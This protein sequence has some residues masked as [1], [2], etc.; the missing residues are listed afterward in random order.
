MVNKGSQR[1]QK[2]PPLRSGFSAP[3]G[4]VIPYGEVNY[5]AKNDRNR[6]RQPS[7]K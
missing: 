3:A 6:S 2:K 4:G 7:G 5:D 1:D